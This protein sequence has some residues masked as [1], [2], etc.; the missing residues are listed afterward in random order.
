MDTSRLFSD[1]SG[2]YAGARPL[3][4]AEMFSFL[5]GIVSAKSS[6][7]DCATGNGQAAIGL[8]RHFDKVCATDVSAEQIANAFSSPNISY[9]V[10]S[11]ENTNFATSSFDLVLVAQ[12]LHWFKYDEFWPEVSR[13]LTSDGVFASCA[14]VWPCIDQDLDALLQTAIVQPTL[15]FWAPNNQLLWDGYKSV[16]FPFELIEAP[17]MQIQNDWSLKQYLDYLKTWSGVRQC[18]KAN[19]WSFFEEAAKGLSAAWGDPEQ[20]KRIV[21][22]LLVHAG[23]QWQG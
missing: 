2:L 6:A 21:H 5:A 14:Y 22:P 11:G 20:R 9:S 1:N 3:Y 12:A 17:E 15:D 16:D 7:W 18:A 13:V 8:A 23:R 19:G 4:P 10:Q